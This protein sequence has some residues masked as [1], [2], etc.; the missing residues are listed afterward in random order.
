MKKQIYMIFPPL[1]L[2]II[3]A[4]GLVN[5][6]AVVKTPSGGPKDTI[7]PVIEGIYPPQSEINFDEDY[8][9]LLFSKYMNKGKVAGNIFIQPELKFEPSWWG[10]RLRINFLE[11]RDS[12]TTYAVSLGT[13]YTDYHGNKP[14]SAFSLIFSTGMKI[15]SGRIVG[16]LFGEKPD[17]YFI[18]AYNLD[19]INKDSLDFSSQKPDYKIQCG[20]SGEFVLNA[21]KPGKYRLIAINDKFSN[22]LYSAGIDEFSAANQDFIVDNQNDNIPFASILKGELID[23]ISPEL[24]SVY[25]KNAKSIIATFSESLSS[26]SVIPSNF[27]VLDSLSEKNVEVKFARFESPEKHNKIELI[28]NETLDTTLVWMMETSLDLADSSGNKILDSASFGYFIPSALENKSLAGLK[29]IPFKDS[30]KNIDPLAPIE[31]EFNLPLKNSPTFSLFTLDSVPEELEVN[32]NNNSNKIYFV[33]SD[34][35]YEKGYRLIV[36]L[37]DIESFFGEN[38]KLLESSSKDTTLLSDTIIKLDF[39]TKKP[40]IYSKISGILADSTQSNSGYILQFI[41]NKNVLSYSQYLEKEGGWNID[42][43]EA[44]NYKIR[45]FCDENKDGKY[46]KGNDNP[47]RFAEKFYFIEKMIEV[48]ER[49]DQEDIIIIL[50]DDKIQ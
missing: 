18:Y 27:S 7:S 31:F 39:F 33:T 6:C 21:L 30:A 25:A 36:D 38:K 47:F 42:S 11:E 28:L 34:L 41:D 12:N 23:R 10:R 4:A 20:T 16:K 26:E 3:L 14:A 1:F 35:E 45:V 19:K 46:N 29:N 15:D 2:T 37:T 22:G 24:Q 17:G 32:I 5:S 49:W 8:V 40:I 50:Q 43:V 9:D 48:K 44:G 13:D